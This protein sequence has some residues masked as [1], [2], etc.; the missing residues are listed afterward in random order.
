MENRILD[1][2]LFD[3]LSKINKDIA[4][5]QKSYESKEKVSQ[6]KKVSKSS[7]L[8]NSFEIKEVTNKK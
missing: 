8:S 4:L 5:S 6:E 7:I 1:R 3:K 2:I